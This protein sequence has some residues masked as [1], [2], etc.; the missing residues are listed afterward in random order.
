MNQTENFKHRVTK[1]A[2]DDEFK[3]Q[4]NAFMGGPVEG[5]EIETP[6]FFNADG[7]IDREKTLNLPCY[8]GFKEN[9]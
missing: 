4:L 6:M 5:I 3:K 9:A 2:A 8:A 1:D 7:T